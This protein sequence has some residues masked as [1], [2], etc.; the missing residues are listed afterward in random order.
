MRIVSLCPSNTE[1]LCALGVGEFLVGLDRSSDWPPE[2][3]HLPRVGPDLTVDVEAV[4]A[5]A[6]DLVFSSL[7]VP[8]ME[9]NVEGLESAGIPQVVLDSQSLEAV[10]GAIQL[11]GRVLGR[12]VQARRVIAD[13]K[14]RLAAV[15]ADLLPWRPRV[16]L[17]WWPRP[18]IVPGR[19][20]WTTEMIRIAGGEA[21]FGDLDVRSTPVDMDRVLARAPD[22]MLTCW[23]GVPHTRQKPESLATRPGW[24]RL[25]AV[26]RGR[27]LPAEERFFGRPGPRVVEGVEW[28]HA[29]LKELSC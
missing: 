24:E 5:L 10:Y 16:F 3:T 20:C 19:H 8:G 23:C 14:G 18:V 7:S 21:L 12:G 17:E 25:E 11:A 4:A 9:R 13:M 26:R 28:L 22:L 29:R 2:I 6:P 27:M 15:E 1:I